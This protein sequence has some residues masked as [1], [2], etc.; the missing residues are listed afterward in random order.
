MGLFSGR[1]VAEPAPQRSM[2]LPFDLSAIYPGAS[3][4]D[5]ATV[6]A[7]GDNAL[8]SIAV[9]A[10]IDLICSLASGLPLDTFRGYGSDRVQLATPSNLQDPGST[11]QGL[12]TGCIRCWCRGCTAATPRQVLGM[13]V[14]ATRGGCRC[15]TGLGAATLVDRQIQW[16]VN[17][18]PWDAPGRFRASP[19]EPGAWPAAGASVIRRH[20]MQIGT[21]LAAAQFGSRWFADGAHR[22][23][24]W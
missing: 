19:C 1:R 7:N 23:G 5:Y 10:A 12:G 2:T 9:G 21:S 6:D 11:G 13:T 8:R 17:S 3:I 20:A 14:P 15:S 18:Q 24:C 22:Q 16:W 4:T